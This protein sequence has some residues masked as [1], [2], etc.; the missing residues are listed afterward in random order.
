MVLWSQQQ[1]YVWFGNKGPLL[2]MRR[3]SGPIAWHVKTDPEGTGE[4]GLQQSGAISSVSISLNSKLSAAASV[5]FDR[6]HCGSMLLDFIL[7]ST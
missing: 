3:L 5:V 7:L 6:G 1:L 4:Q 2:Q